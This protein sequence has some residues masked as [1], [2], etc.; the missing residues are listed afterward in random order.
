M[1]AEEKD[2]LAEESAEDAIVRSKVSYSKDA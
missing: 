2:D 1:D